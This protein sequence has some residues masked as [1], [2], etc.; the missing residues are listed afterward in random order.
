MRPSLLVVLL[1]STAVPSYAA[2]EAVD[3]LE[4]MNSSTIY[5]QKTVLPKF[6]DVLVKE[7][8]SHLLSRDDE[9]EEV[10]ETSITTFSVEDLNKSLIE[11]FIRRKRKAMGAVV[12]EDAIPFF[13]DC[14]VTTLAGFSGVLG[15]FGAG[16][17][18]FKAL[19]DCKDFISELAGAGSKMYDL[20]SD[21]LFKYELDYVLKKRFFPEN[22]Q[23]A[24]EDRFSTSRKDPKN[25]KEAITDYFPLVLNLPTK[26]KEPNSDF[27]SAL[28]VL[29][30]G[31]I[32]RDGSS[33]A[34]HLVN[35]G[36]SHYSHYKEGFGENSAPKPILYLTGPAGI[37]KT[38]IAQAL[39]E[40]LQL[41]LCKVSLAGGTAKVF[42]DK[43][44]AGQFLESFTQPGA[45]LNGVV[46]FDEAN[47]SVN[48]GVVSKNIPGTDVINPGKTKL[49][50]NSDSATWLELLDPE[51]KKRI[52]PFLNA[53]VDISHCLIICAGNDIPQNQA[54]LNRM[55]MIE[56][57]GLK[58]EFKRKVTLE[59][60]LPKLLKSENP[61]M[62]LTMTD[63]DMTVVEKIFAADE[64]KAAEKAEKAKK[65]AEKDAKKAEKKADKAEKGNKEEKGGKPEKEDKKP[66]KEGKAEKVDES[67][68]D[69]DDA[70]FRT[71]KADL[72]RYINSIR[73]IRLNEFNLSKKQQEKETQMKT[74]PETKQMPVT[75]VNGLR[76]RNV[77]K[78][79]WSANC[80]PSTYVITANM[81]M[82]W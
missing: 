57:T 4:K 9:M 66:E 23:R 42:G 65:A 79:E 70:G 18:L 55:T 45:A 22:L 69:D 31:Y 6:K 61:I 41:P 80:D 20:E 72:E 68:E 46:F 39:A 52:F 27:E 24:I 7:G 48:V 14:G 2:K 73:L 19:K 25:L 59:K 12:G 38:Y 10:A 51:T 36:M 37:G 76:H 17:A 5:N 26:S 16:M 47:H 33:L 74:Q 62:R 21:P 30:D 28:R 15:N 77:Q 64:Q 71:I 1:L 54:L 81:L 29:T 32:T 78:D 63:L 8:L 34:D 43:S 53:G 60:I 75:A 13:C 44:N 58:P 40:A 82:H 49:S 56:I 35:A 50:Q 3:V 11:E 67:E